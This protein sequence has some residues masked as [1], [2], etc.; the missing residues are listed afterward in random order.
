MSKAYLHK[1]LLHTGDSLTSSSSDSSLDIGESSASYFNVK[2][3]VSDIFVNESKVNFY[4][5]SGV[6]SIK[7]EGCS[8]G[9]SS[10]ESSEN[11][12]YRPYSATELPGKK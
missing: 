9:I 7:S 8:V 11:G 2:T 12:D 5:P 10:E 4:K 1:I 6:I 3:S